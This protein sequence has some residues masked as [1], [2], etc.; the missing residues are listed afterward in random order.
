MHTPKAGDI[1]KHFK[2]NQY[3]I[4][5]LGKHS[6]TEEDCVV[7]KALYGKHLVWI[8]PLKMFLEEVE[9][10]AKKVPRFRLVEKIKHE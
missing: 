2:G 1:Y 10:E 8:R 3:K 5:A 7:Y 9:V 4:I 6:E